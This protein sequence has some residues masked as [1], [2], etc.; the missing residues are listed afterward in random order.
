M[1]AADKAREVV[2]DLTGT[3]W[4]AA[5]EGGLRDAARAWRGFADDVDDVTVA[6][7][8]A[9]RSLIEHNKGEAV[10]A[11]ADPFWRRYHRDGS[12]WLKDL[13]E[14]ARAMAKALD[15]Y[16]D[17]VHSARKKLEHELEIVGATLVA[18]T[19]LALFTAGISEGAAVAAAAT[20]ADV[21][22]GLGVAVTEEIAAIAGTT[23]AT[24]AFAGVES[25]TVDLAVAQPVSVALGESKGFSLDEAADAGLYGMAFGG[26]FGAGAGTVRAATEAGDLGSFFAGPAGSSRPGAG[27]PGELDALG[28]DQ[29]RLIRQDDDFGGTHNS[30][31]LRKSRF[32]PDSGIVPAD[33]D[34]G[35]TP[36]QHVLGGKNRAAKESS[37]YTSF[38]PKDGTGKVY[39]SQEID[40]DYQRLQKDIDAGHVHGVEVLP[41]AQVQ[42]SIGDEIDRAAGHPV[43]VPPTLKPHEVPDFVDGLGLSRGKSRKV[44]DRVMALLN[45]RRDGEWLISGVVPKEYVTGPYATSRP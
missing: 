26:L 11:F 37:Q 4:P 31:G 12:G 23:L 8:R 14:A 39:G 1:S 13:A 5:D 9:A 36:L 17:S 27:L 19:A 7:D 25:V 21:A 22:A 28:P 45:T 10:S 29:L 20:V 35:I 34:G 38:A 30:V 18:G 3:W 32:D 24:A 41:P 33:P 43:E 6:A 42:R 40:L 2:Q 15:T 44:T 16:A